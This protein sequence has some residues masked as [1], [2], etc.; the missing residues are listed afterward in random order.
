MRA[1]YHTHSKWCHHG[2][3]EIEDFLESAVNAG[4]EEIAITEHVPHKD[5]LDY[6]RMWWE[7]FIP[8]DQSLEKAIQ[9]YR[10]KI[11]IIKGF[12]C[13]YYPEEIETYKMFQKEYGYELLMLGQHRAGK[14]REFDIFAPKGQ[15]ELQAYADA[16]CE[17]LSTGLFR[18][19]AHP[20]VALLDYNENKWDPVC[21][22]TMR[23]IY[24]CCEKYSI[25][26]E[27]NANGIRGQRRY[28]DKN[29]FILSKEYDLQYLI[30]S[31]AHFPE[32]VYDEAV[33]EAE[34]FAKELDLPL[35]EKL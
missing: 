32:A 19:L 12:E 27:I 28:P 15:K 25:P 33:Q 26:V 11:K 6:N 5:N 4:L 8:F 1:N 13:E 35:L 16:V 23:Q 7:D 31:D 17:G 30:N 10:Q 24:Q 29:A 21:E 18:F 14:N 3:G 9:K 2:T 20:D 34:R 22:K